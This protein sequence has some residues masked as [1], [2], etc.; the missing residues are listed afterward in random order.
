MPVVDEYENHI[1]T[2]QSMNILETMAYSVPY[3]NVS[4]YRY[5]AM[6]LIFSLLGCSLKASQ[7]IVLLVI[8]LETKRYKG[9]QLMVLE[10]L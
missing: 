8:L 6:T 5:Q 10:K 2:S 4:F 1:G 9:L 7:I 3:V